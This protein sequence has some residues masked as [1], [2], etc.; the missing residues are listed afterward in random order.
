MFTRASH[1]ERR[2]DGAPGARPA[3]FGGPRR[4]GR[5]LAAAACLLLAVC[6]AAAG[7]RRHDVSDDL[8]LQ[9]AADWR[10]A[11]VGRVDWDGVLGSGSLVAPQWVLTAAHVVEDATG[12]VTFTLD[13]IVH[14]AASWV[15]HPDWGGA[16][17]SEGDL[18][19]VELTAP[20]WDVAPAEIYTAADEVDRVATIVGYGQTGTGTSGARP[21]TSGTKR[22]GDNL[23]GGLGS[24]YGYSDVFV[25]ADFDAP[26]T[27][28]GG[29]SEALD[30]EY[31]G[32]PGDS[33]GGWFVDV[34]GQTY[35]AAVT[36]FAFAPSGGLLDYKYGD[37]MGATR[38][39]PYLDW[40]DLY[41]PDPPQPGDINL[42]GLVNQTDLDV[43]LASFGLQTGANWGDGD[44]N[45]DAAVDDLDLSILLSNWT[46][47]GQGQVP[48]PGPLALVAVGGLA[49]LDRR[50]VR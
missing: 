10:Y 29:K 6:P 46:P 1:A 21:G 36:S 40:I 2:N 17:A 26:R 42:D 18:A 7:V 20:V 25:L 47:P 27:H 43:L 12:T 41:L 16:A 11:S 31:L 13:G 19:M 9:L 3:G 15:L 44:F 38:I 33:G 35:L 48:A 4:P 22:A 28:G 5:P 23:I 50:R 14:E 24:G 32:A 49:L 30:L 37:A 8:H 39:S 45:D 34:S